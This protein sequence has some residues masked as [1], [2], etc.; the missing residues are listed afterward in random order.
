V[1][2]AFIGLAASVLQLGAITCGYQIIVQYARLPTGFVGVTHIMVALAPGL[3]YGLFLAR[4]CQHLGPMYWCGQI[5]GTVQPLSTILIILLLE[6]EML[7][8][9]V[10]GGAGATAVV[11]G[12]TLGGIYCGLGAW[13]RTVRSRQLDQDG[14]HC[15]QCG[16]VLVHQNDRPCS[17]CGCPAGS[18]TSPPGGRVYRLAGT[19]ERHF[20]VVMTLLVSIAGG[21]AALHAWQMWPIWSFHTTFGDCVP[22]YHVVDDRVTP[23]ASLATV[24]IPGTSGR[25]LNVVVYRQTSFGEVGMDIVLSTSAKPDERPIELP[26]QARLSVSGAWRILRHGLP[27]SAYREFERVAREYNAPPDTPTGAD[28]PVVIVPESTL[29]D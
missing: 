20:V 12:A 19:L 27:D 25:F 22:I 8:S 4:C 9:V 14:S 1:L 28:V 10:L 15:P 21:S 29:F 2:A 17:E 24:P 26:I 18:P 11:T 3:L 5:L 6:P 13:Y 7:S 16:Y 23:L